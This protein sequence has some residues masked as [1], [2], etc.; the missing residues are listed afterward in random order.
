MTF[1]E[2]TENDIDLME[3]KRLTNN[4]AA[5]ATGVV[6]VIDVI[7]AFTTAAYAFASGAQDIVL[8]DTLESALALRERFRAPGVQGSATHRPAWVMGE[9]NGVKPESF[10]LG[11]SPAALAGVD[12]SGRRLIQRTSAGTQ[13]VV[14]SSRGDNVVFPCSLCVASATV[15]AIQR[16]AP[17][18]VSFVITGARQ[19]NA[20]HTG[21]EDR[22][23]ADYVEALLRGETPDPQTFVR[24]VLDSPNGRSFLDSTR[25]EFPA[26]D[27]AYCTAIDRFDYSLNVARQE[28]LLVM[29]PQL[30]EG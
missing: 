27:L 25:P 22:A 19:E 10:D 18:T 4:Q 9:V 30:V 7:R 23:C 24:R 17:H 15:R 2:P 12:L 14:R 8:T 20:L 26:A 28:D 3:F 21:E 1:G 6:V 13:G 11:N 16:L 5:R 29:T